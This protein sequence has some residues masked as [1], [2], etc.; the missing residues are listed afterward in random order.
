VCGDVLNLRD[1]LFSLYNC[2][3]WTLVRRHPCGVAQVNLVWLVECLFGLEALVGV[4]REK[5]PLQDFLRGVTVLTRH[6]EDSARVEQGKNAHAA[7]ASM[8]ELSAAYEA[9]LLRKKRSVPAATEPVGRTL[10]TTNAMV[11]AGGVESTDS[12]REL[13]TG[14]EA[15]VAIEGG[16]AN[17]RTLSRETQGAEV[18]TQLT[19]ATNSV[20]RKRRKT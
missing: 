20:T 8:E 6:V 12:V 19:E 2:S 7:V 13:I 4:F 1:C 3:E 18:T 5:A 14:S 10:A 11:G 17:N 16:V 15:V 9:Y